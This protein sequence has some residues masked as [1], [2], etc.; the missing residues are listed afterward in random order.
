MRTIVTPPDTIGKPGRKDSVQYQLG[1]IIQNSQD[2]AL[3]G[4]IDMIKLYNKVPFLK[5]YQ[6]TQ[7]TSNKAELL[8]QKK[9]QPDTIPKPPD[10]F[11]IK[12]LLRLIMS[13]RNIN[14]TYNMTSGTILPGFT[15]TPRLFG[16]DRNWDAPG[17]GFVLGGQDPY[18]PQ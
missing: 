5:G 17:W 9:A 18:L 10:L 4:R 16:L 1:N 13:L 2:Q 8:K 7:K 14:G 12:G 6:H 11:L 3:T 15:P